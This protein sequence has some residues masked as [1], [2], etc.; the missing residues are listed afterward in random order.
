MS[1]VKIGLVGKPN[2]GKS[3]IFST[4]TESEVEVANY[5]FTTIKP[6]VGIA[7]FRTLC[8]ETEINGKCNPR[9][10]KCVDGIRYVPIEVIDVPG[11]IPGASEGKGMG[12]EFL[13]NIRD[14]DAIIH[15]FDSS[16]T[17]SLEGTPSGE[18]IT[19]P[20]EEI[21][22]VRAEMVK[23]MSSKIA[24][25]WDKFARKVES[26]KDK[27]ERLLLK[28]VASFGLNERQVAEILLKESF[29]SRLSL[30]T[31]DS[32]DKFSDAVFRYIKPII[33]L[34]NKA[35][36]AKPDVVRKIKEKY[37]DS[38]FISA[39]YELALR[40]AFGASLINSVNSEFEI[41]E[42]CSEKQKEALL[43]IKKFFKREHV[44]RID[45]I[46]ETLIRDILSYI[47][48]FPVY[49]ENHW[50]DKDGNVLPD[51]FL[52]KKGYTALDL[53]FK[54][55]TDIGEGFIRAIDCRKRMVVSKDHELENGDII[56]IVS[57]T[58]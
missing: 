11:L 32:F 5:P 34:G 33:H 24:K 31:Q 22:F 47:V 4:I 52:M 54:V 18:E 9:E 12:N 23:W 36:I 17:T 27:T 57:K 45:E 6:N 30:W 35:D 7:L 16:G 38:F 44:N 3:T 41:G 14:S 48:V 1:L 39:E 28:K 40:K 10:G 55:H 26:T 46:F 37:P 15:V 21:E 53:A 13:D 19:D 56:R 42:K 25:D 43:L 8:P 58:K 2:V 51:A 49:D 50:T 29:P 20:L